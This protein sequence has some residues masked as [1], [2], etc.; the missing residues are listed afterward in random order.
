[1]RASSSASSPTGTKHTTMRTWTGSPCSWCGTSLWLSSTRLDDLT[2]R[3]GVSLSSLYLA[4]AVSPSICRACRSICRLDALKYLHESLFI[5]HGKEHF[6]QKPAFLSPQVGL[7][8][9]LTCLSSTSYC[10]AS[11]GKRV[12][13]SWVSALP[14]RH[15]RLILS[16]SCL[17]IFFFSVFV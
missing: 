9:A 15:L 8:T 12:F 1:M 16:S 11:L 14:S 5:N 2:L 7:V 17:I 6:W 3:V 4:R 13:E 10:Q